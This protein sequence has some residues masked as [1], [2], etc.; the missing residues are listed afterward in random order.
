MDEVN[1]LVIDNGSGSCKAG[2]TGDDVPKCVFP[3]VIGHP[4]AVA[5]GADNKDSYVGNEA[6]SKRDM[7]TLKYPIERGIVTDWNGM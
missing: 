5:I 2:F 3:S 7:L 6:Q 4:R 1:S